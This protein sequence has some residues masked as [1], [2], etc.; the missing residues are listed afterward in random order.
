MEPN[1][2]PSVKRPRAPSSPSSALSISPGSGDP[3]LKASRIIYPPDAGSDIT[4]SSVPSGSTANG[5]QSTTTSGASV[6]LLCTL[7]P[8]CNHKP[9]PIAN[10][11][12]LERHY[13]KYHAHVCEDQNCG[14]VFPE[15]RLLAL[16]SCAVLSGK[17]TD[18][19][20]LPFVQHQTE[21]HDP[22]A[23]I[24]KERGDKIVRTTVR[25]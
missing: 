20:N 5:H 9:A 1:A 19:A 24:L 15:A 2:T 8:T 11:A 14:C 4:N 23:Q 12:E 10:T 21:C 25:L 17:D 18:G 3:P 7:P 13:A 16:V 6:P 22:L